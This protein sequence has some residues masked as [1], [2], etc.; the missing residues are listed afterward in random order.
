MDSSYDSLPADNSRPD[1]RSREVSNAVKAFL[2]KQFCNRESHVLDIGCGRGG[3]VHKFARAGVEWY[4]G[5]D[6]SAPSIQKARERAAG[7][8]YTEFIFTVLDASKWFALGETFSVVTCFFALHYFF[9]TAESAKQV[10][11]NVSRHLTLGGR[12]IC[13]TVDP[14]VLGN[15][16]TEGP[17]VAQFPNGGPTGEAF[18]DGYE[19]TFD[20]SVD[21]EV[22]YV[23]NPLVLESVAKE[24]GLVL[25]SSRNM[26]DVYDH[27]LTPREYTDGE[28][29]IVGLYRVYVFARS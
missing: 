21:R 17:V 3:D 6:K 15:G 1:L 27:Y 12:F 9:K 4:R 13:I 11:F 8:G 29:R 20:G 24:N 19:F 10:L 14:E 16:F 28:R 22:E 7:A 25:R 5:V 26:L 18:G 23:V 2:I